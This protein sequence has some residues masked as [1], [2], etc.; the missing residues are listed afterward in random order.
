MKLGILKEPEGEMRVPVVPNSIPKLS[1]SGLELLVENGAGLF[2]N[3]S[4][5]E[6]EIKEQKIGLPE[7]TF[8]RVTH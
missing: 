3:H 1:K 5:A 7:K 8:L 2:A 4:D 6:Y